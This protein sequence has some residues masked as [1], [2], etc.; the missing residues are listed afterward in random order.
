MIDPLEWLDKETG[1]IFYNGK[2]DSMFY[3]L[4][5]GINWDRVELVDVIEKKITYSG[6]ATGVV[7]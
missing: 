1:V 7:G 4:V 3:G 2:L 6:E 5:E